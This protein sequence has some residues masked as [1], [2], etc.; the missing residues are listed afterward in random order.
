M[1]DAAGKLSPEESERARQWLKDHWKTWTCPFSGDTNWE[2]GHVIVNAPSQPL[3]GE[4]YPLLVV[5]CAGCGNT[6]FVN[7]IKAGVVKPDTPEP[8]KDPPKP[9]EN[10]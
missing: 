1:P 5:I 10:G 2:L 9:K 8:P 4:V 6:V 7:A 3:G